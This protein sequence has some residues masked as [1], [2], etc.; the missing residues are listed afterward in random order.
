[1]VRDALDR[2]AGETVDR[3]LGEGSGGGTGNELTDTLLAWLRAGGK[4]ATAADTLGV[5]RH[6]VRTRLDRIAQICEVDLDDPVVRA[7][8]LLVAVTRTAG[9]SRA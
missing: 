9:S 8:L 4:V 6:T 7:E 2:R 5:H 1:A 3:L